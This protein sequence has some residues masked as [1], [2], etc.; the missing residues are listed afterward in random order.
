MGEKYIFTFEDFVNYQMYIYSKSK[1]YKNTKRFVVIFSILFFIF[2][3]FLIYDKSY[4]VGSF[5][6]FFGFVY[7][8]YFPWYVKKINTKHFKN[9]FGI[10]GMDKRREFFIEVHDGY[11]LQKNNE[12]VSEYKMAYED[13]FEIDEVK[14]AFYVRFNTGLGFIINKN[15]DNTEKTKTYLKNLAGSLHVKYVD[16]TNWK[17]S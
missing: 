2:G 4:M 10:I 15:S 7:F 3:V 16:D 12:T 6:I 8:F 1:N 14:D 5:F 9:T 11:M 17:W 13:I